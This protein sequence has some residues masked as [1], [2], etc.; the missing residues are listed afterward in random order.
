MATKVSSDNLASQ[1]KDF[2]NSG[3]LSRCGRSNL[4][5]WEKKI[6]HEIGALPL[7][8]LL[9]LELGCGQTK[10]NNIPG[11]YVAFDLGMSVLRNLNGTRIQGDMQVLP[12]SDASV[13]F[14]FS[15]AAIEHVP[16]PELVLNEV[17][18]VLKPG[19]KAFLAPAWFC[20]PWAAQ[21]LPVKKYS[22]LSWNDK[23]AKA[24][25]I[26]RNNLFWRSMFIFPKRVWREI[27]FFFKKSPT[28]F[29][30]QRLEPNLEEYIMSDSDAFT[31]MDPHAVLLYF[32]SRGFVVEPNSIVKRILFR[33][34][35]VVVS[36]P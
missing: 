21:G 14:I 31:S 18:R 9:I 4:S 30:Y 16:N 20:R 35:F 34:S 2:Y 27:L 33:N 5:A 1:A 11:R 22:E 29:S 7:Q 8:N 13:D 12:F 23:I 3:A 32:L 6:I 25:L 19:G 17:E 36:R 26:I 24:S 15:I 28:S 10:W